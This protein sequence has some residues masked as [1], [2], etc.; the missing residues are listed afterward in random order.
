MELGFNV[1]SY[2]E[3]YPNVLGL[4]RHDLELRGFS[5]ETLEIE[6]D[7]NGIYVKYSFGLPEF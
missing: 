1:H 7:D 5:I 4:V 3:R 2:R 6:P